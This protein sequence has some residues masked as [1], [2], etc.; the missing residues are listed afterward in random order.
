[1]SKSVHLSVTAGPMKG[2]AFAFEEHDTFLFG[3]FW[4]LS[5]KFP[6]TRLGDVPLAAAALLALLLAAGWGARG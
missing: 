3:K 6:Y 5:P 4:G 2:K 1:M